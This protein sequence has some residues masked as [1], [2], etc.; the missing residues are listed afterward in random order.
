MCCIDLTKNIK[1]YVHF[2]D[3]A[4]QKDSQIKVLLRKKSPTN[5][6][7]RF[8]EKRKGELLIQKGKV[9][10]ASTAS[11]ASLAKFIT[12]GIFPNP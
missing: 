6:G 8:T 9:I 11:E 4:P 7:G 12:T 3:T 2:Y 1:I 10:V 5:V